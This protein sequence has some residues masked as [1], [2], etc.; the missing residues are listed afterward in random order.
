MKS[1]LVPTDFSDN[2]YNA[3][4]YAFGIFKNES[5]TFHLLNAFTFRAN[6]ED[7]VL[8]DNDT[9]ILGDQSDDAVQELTALKKKAMAEKGQSDFKFE[10]IAVGGDLEDAIDAVVR[11]MQFD[12]IVMG[13]QGATGAIETFLGSNTV[14][15]IKR[16]S[17]VP[18]I[19]VPDEFGFSALNKILYPTAYE[20]SITKENLWIV[21]YV[22]DLW[23][24][25]IEVLY[26]EG[27]NEPLDEKAIKNKQNLKGILPKTK[28]NFVTIEGYN[29]VAKSIMAYANKN[30]SD[31]II[32][33]YHKHGFLSQL[34]K[35][36]VV[37]KVAFQSKIPLLVIPLDG[38]D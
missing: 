28:V 25:N 32:L 33:H 19:V 8:S 1:I 7:I 3:L 18:V 35:E 14:S 4:L 36:P 26:V 15:V 9:S 16:I 24:G 34:F 30:D 17:D 20:Y 31:L 21:S 12:F 23:N 11:E 27:E 2:A 38:D 10:T 37:K 5:V 13:T 22:S 29:S 6:L